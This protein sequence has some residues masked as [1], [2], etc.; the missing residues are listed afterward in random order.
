MEK[1]YCVKHKK[2]TGNRNTQ[3]VITENGRTMMK[4]ICDV[5]PHVKTRFVKSQKGGTMPGIGTGITVIQ[6]TTEAAMPESKQAFKDFWSGKT[7]KRA[8][9]NFKRMFTKS[10][11]PYR[12]ITKKKIPGCISYIHKNGKWFNFSCPDALTMEETWNR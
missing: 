11:P 8:G 5:S 2:L 6:K 3:F 10:K 12:Q 4:S 7:F 1:T 9:R